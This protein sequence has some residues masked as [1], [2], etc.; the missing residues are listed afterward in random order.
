MGRKVLSEFLPGMFLA[1][2]QKGGST[3]QNGGWLSGTPVISVSLVS[4]INLSSIP[5]S[6]L[7]RL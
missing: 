5:D 4:K 3:R 6:A 7:D 2:Q 1:K